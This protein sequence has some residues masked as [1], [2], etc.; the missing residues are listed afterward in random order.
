[1]ALGLHYIC[2][3]VA[4]GA[5]IPGIK[6]ASTTA[7]VFALLVVDA[8]IGIPVGG[9]ATTFQVSVVIVD[10]DAFGSEEVAVRDIW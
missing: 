9:V 2:V 1:M 4:P 7:P 3:L 10:I 8:A 5:T 6:T